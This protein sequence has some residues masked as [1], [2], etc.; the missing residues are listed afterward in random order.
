MK[1]L[2]A[3]VLSLSFASA[4]AAINTSTDQTG[5]LTSVGT[6]QSRTFNEYDAAGRVTASQHVLQGHASV[7]RSQ[8]GYPQSPASTVGLGTAIVSQTFPDGETVTY[9]YDAGGQQVSVRSTFQGVTDD[10]VRDV[11]FNAR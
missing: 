8:F 6:S 7:F 1:T 4:H 5:R 3:F 9:T 11:R 10:V 2:F